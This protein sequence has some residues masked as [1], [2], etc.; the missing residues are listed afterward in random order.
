MEKDWQLV[1][2]TDKPYKA[3]LVRCM[4]EESGV[5][6]IIMNKQDSSY[7]FGEI[8]VYVHPDQYEQALNTVKSS[9]NE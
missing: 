8:E 7:M 6:P 1:Y 4:L 9:E 5:E 2:S 3:E